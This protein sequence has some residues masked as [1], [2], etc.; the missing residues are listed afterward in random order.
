MVGQIVS[1]TLELPLSQMTQDALRE[2]RKI[3]WLYTHQTKA[4]DA[5]RRGK[6]VIVSTSTASGKSIIY[7]VSVQNQNRLKY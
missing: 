2:S 5:I 3:Q 7:Q 6:H 4:I 1:G